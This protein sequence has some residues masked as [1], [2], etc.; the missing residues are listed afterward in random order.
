MSPMVKLEPLHSLWQMVSRLFVFL[1]MKMQ[2]RMNLMSMSLFMNLGII[3][4]ISSAV[5]IQLVDLI[6]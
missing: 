6:L 3:L 1:V 5:R 4:K 2:I